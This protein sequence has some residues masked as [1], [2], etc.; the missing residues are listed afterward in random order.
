MDSPPAATHPGASASGFAGVHQS[1]KLTT[2]D[3]IGGIYCHI[4][5]ITYRNKKDYD[6]HYASHNT[7]DVIVYTCVACHKEIASYPSFRGH[8]YTQHV[9]KDKF[10]Y[11]WFLFTM[12]MAEYAQK[13]LRELNLPEHR[14]G[15]R[16]TK[17]LS[18]TSSLNN[19]SQHHYFNW[20]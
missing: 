9:T 6:S 16:K 15:Q 17:F 14:E 8:C 13:C 18:K 12:S 2:I 5:H 20:C 4:C 7:G 19:S 10:K 1:L 3:L 11:V